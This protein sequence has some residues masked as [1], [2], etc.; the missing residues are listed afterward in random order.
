M[1]VSEAITCHLHFGHKLSKKD[2]FATRKSVFYPFEDEFKGIMYTLFVE[3]SWYL[4]KGEFLH[5]KST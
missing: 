2:S 5:Y 4:K 1:I 3:T